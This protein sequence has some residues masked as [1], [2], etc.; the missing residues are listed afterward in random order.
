MATLRIEFEFARLALDF[1]KRREVSQT[2]FGD[3]A[4]V[5]CVQIMQLSSRVG[6]TADLND[7]AIEQCLVARVVIADELARPVA[8]ELTGVHS[9]TAVG[10]VV[11]DRL[12][13]IVFARRVA[14]EIRPMRAT[15]A[16]L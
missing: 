7:P 3:L 6:E 12:Q 14:P 9:G 10:K 4:A 1:V 5:I 2:L 11:D 15:E 16:G 8:Q 13:L